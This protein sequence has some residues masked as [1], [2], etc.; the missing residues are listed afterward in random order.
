MILDTTN[1]DIQ[2]LV[3][4]ALS[5]ANA[6]RV[7]AYIQGD[8]QARAYYDQLCQQKALLQQWWRQEH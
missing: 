4:C 8:A 5:P 1:L 6:E 3:D 7:M 2:A